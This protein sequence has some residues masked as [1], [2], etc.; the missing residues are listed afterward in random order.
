LAIADNACLILSIHQELDKLLEEQKGENKI[1][2]T[3]RG[4]GPA[5]EDRA[6]RRAIRICDLRDE[7]VLKDRLENLLFYHNLL[8]RSLGE[9]DV[10]VADLINEINE[11]KDFVLS[12]SHLN[13]I[14]LNYLNYYY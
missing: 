3:G 4:I 6:G 8:R 5:Y 14:F 13:P 10:T 1:G 9:K 7:A 12:Y 11:V 2:T